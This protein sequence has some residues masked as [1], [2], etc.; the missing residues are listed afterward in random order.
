MHQSV[1]DS[2]INLS[3]V[4][5]ICTPYIPPWSLKP[6]SFEFFLHLLDNKSEVTPNV[7]QSTFH[8]LVS[9]F[10][11]FARLFTDGSQIGE[12]VGAAA[13]VG[14][15]VSKKRL[16]NGLSIYSA[17]ARGL[18]MALDMVHQ[19][20]DRPFLFFSDSLS[21]L[22]CLKNRDLS[23]PLIAD[24]LC[25]V[26]ILLSSGTQVAFMWV[27]SHVGLAGNSAADIAA[28]AA[29]LLPISNLPVPHPDFCCLIRSHLLKQWL[30]NWNSETLKKLH[31]IEP[32]VNV[33]NLYRLPSRNGIIIHRLRI[34]HS[35]LTHGHLLRGEI[36]PRC[37]AC[38]V[39]LKVEHILLHCVSFAIARDPSFNMSVTTLS[40]YFSK[41]PCR[42]IIE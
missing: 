4:A 39:K 37:S 41:V 35:F 31:A 19:T 3:S 18:L 28:E 22:Q 11:G 23:D 30:E 14:S 26:H 25:R 42:S 13:I 9:Q 20:A 7:Y 8:E 32:K 27:P 21:C 40:E 6:P 15:Q 38:D 33:F 12:S 34:G 29:L 5:N 36:C 10:H 2:G 1:L 24:I 17:K 16:P